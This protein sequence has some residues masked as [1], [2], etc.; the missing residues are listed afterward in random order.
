VAIPFP[1]TVVVEAMVVVV[2]T[3]L[4]DVVEIEEEPVVTAGMEELEDEDEFSKL[5]C[6]Q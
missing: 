2:M 4:V 5:I 3:E 6:T 1:D